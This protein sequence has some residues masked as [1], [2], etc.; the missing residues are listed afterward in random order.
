MKLPLNNGETKKKL[1]LCFYLVYGF[2]FSRSET[3]CWFKIYVKYRLVK[4]RCDRTPFSIN[5]VAF[6]FIDRRLNRY[7]SVTLLRHVRAQGKQRLNTIIIEYCLS[8]A[9]TLAIR[10]RLDFFTR[11]RNRAGTVS[12]LLKRSPQRNFTGNCGDNFAQ[13][14]ET[15]QNIRSNYISSNYDLHTLSK[16]CQREYIWRNAGNDVNSIARS[17]RKWSKIHLFY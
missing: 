17:N 2:F 9:E 8:I 1:H 3:R 11:L 10:K 6:C 4:Y 15:L 16:K 5:R 7:Q 13:N 12:I 14:A